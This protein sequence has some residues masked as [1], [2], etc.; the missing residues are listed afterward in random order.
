VH[1]AETSKVV[2]SRPL[3]VVPLVMKDCRCI[4]CRVEDNAYMLLLSWR[5][6]LSRHVCTVAFGCDNGHMTVGAEHCL[7]WKKKTS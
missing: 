3:E 6:N 4:V 2:G 5:Q 7:W 1:L